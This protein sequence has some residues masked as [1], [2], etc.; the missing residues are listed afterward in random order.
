MK[1][2][3]FVFFCLFSVLHAEVNESLTTEEKIALFSEYTGYMFGRELSLM[4][5]PYNAEALARGFKAYEAGSPSNIPVDE[6][7]VFELILSI[8]EELFEKKAEENRIQAEAFFASI[9]K[10]SAV[11]MLIDKQLYYE[12]IAAGNDSEVV[13]EK[14]E[15]LVRYSLHTLDGMEITNTFEY[16]NPICIPLI[17]AIPGFVKGVVGMKQSERRKLYVHPDL[18]YHRGGSVPPNSVLIFDV[19]VIGV[20]SICESK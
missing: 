10:N 9:S 7:K 3:V 14:S 16:K 11:V 20:D 8:Q 6:E 1:L 5:L 19:E 15:P 2:I 4:K 18:A 13:L 17:D 12:V